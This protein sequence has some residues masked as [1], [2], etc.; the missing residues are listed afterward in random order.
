MS[1]PRGGWQSCAAVLL[2]QCC[3]LAA[4]IADGDV[5]DVALRGVAAAGEGAAG[6]DVTKERRPQFV[7]IAAAEGAGH[8]GMAPWL[9]ALAERA[10]GYCVSADCPKCHAAVGQVHT[11][12]P[13]PASVDGAASARSSSR[14]ALAADSSAPP[15]GAAVDAL[16]TG[17]AARGHVA[18]FYGKSAF[19]S[20]AR[21]DD[22]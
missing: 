4:T 18:R 11:A 6:D 2:L 8:H 5:D 12:A 22:G 7:Y 21:H 1:C 15:G 9:T 13:P 20:A 17:C 10:P 3:C 19:P 16:G 14:R